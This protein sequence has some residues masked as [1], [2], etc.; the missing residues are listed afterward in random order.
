MSKLQ[1]FHGIYFEGPKKVHFLNYSLRMKNLTF[2]NFLEYVASSSYFYS[3]ISNETNS[4]SFV[5]KRFPVT[6]TCRKGPGYA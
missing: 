5:R 1:S 4:C 3:I 2:K 6:Q